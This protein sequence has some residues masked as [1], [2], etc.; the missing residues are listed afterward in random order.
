M[1]EAGD[2]SAI[3]DELYLLPF[4]R[5]YAQFLGLDASLISRQFVASI[6]TA[7]PCARETALMLWPNYHG[8]IW[9][10]WTALSFRG[11]DQAGQERRL[12]G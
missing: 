4:A 8:D 11:R 12:G 9:L 7:E 10:H 3:A 5:G 1:L 6:Y 2:Y